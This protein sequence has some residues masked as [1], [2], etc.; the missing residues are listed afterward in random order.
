MAL[1]INTNTSIQKTEISATTAPE[2]R[3]SARVQLNASIMQASLDVSISAKN[4][5]LALLFRS[6]IDRI[7]EELAPTLGEN[8]I[9]NAASQDNSPEGTAGRIVAL[10]TGFYEAYKAQHPG[11]D[12]ADVLQN[13]MDTIGGGFEKGFNEAVDILKSLQV[14]E[15]DIASGI[16]KTYELVQ[17][18]YADFKQAQ[19][20]RLGLGSQAEVAAASDQK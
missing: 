20:E 7:N 14:F 8:A 18:G 17:Q 11:E 16:D 4:E 6:A 19:L 3:Q 12:E 13:F 2:G 9:Q 15:G 5:P 1:S 10:S